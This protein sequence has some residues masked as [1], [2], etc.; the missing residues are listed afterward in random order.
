[1][2]LSCLGLVVG[3]TSQVFGIDLIMGVDNSEL[4]IGTVIWR[5]RTQWE[6]FIWVS[7]DLS[8]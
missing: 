5:I 2:L 7:I 4:G 8:C 1:M 3:N 6:F